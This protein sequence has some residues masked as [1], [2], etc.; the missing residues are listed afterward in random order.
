MAKQNFQKVD[1]EVMNMINRRRILQLI[2]QSH[3]IS[4]AEIVK[5]TGLAA[6]TVSRIVDRLVQQ[7]KL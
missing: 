5:I 3:S 6:P 4:R 2:R 1:A 7:D